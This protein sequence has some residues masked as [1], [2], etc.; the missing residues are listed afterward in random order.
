MRLIKEIKPDIIYSHS[1]KAG[2]VVRIPAKIMGI[3]NIYNPHGWAFDMDASKTKRYIYILIERILSRFTDKIICI[4][5][6]EKELALKKKITLKEKI[7]VIENGIDID[8]F[9]NEVDSS[10]LRRRL[11]IKDDELV[12][13]MVARITEQKSPYTFLNIAEQITKLIPEAK[14]IFVGDGDLKDEIQLAI[15][16][17]GLEKNCLITG[18]VDNTKEYIDLF[19]YA[20]LT[21][22][23][24]GFGLAVTEYMACK[25]VVLASNVGGIT[26]IIEDNID[27]FLIDDYSGRKYVEKIMHLQENEAE[28]DKLIENAY[29]KVLRKYNSK[30]LY[31]VQIL[32]LRYY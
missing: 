7:E 28:K 12:I 25:K 6:Y 15:E 21:S 4:S 16:K 30:Q 23:W 19:D 5:N 22:K 24:E 10:S 8:K 14:C 1:S 26:N 9:T 13:G 11:G 32:W 20:L 29:N 27:G 3:T 31:T 17:R 18:W 2:G